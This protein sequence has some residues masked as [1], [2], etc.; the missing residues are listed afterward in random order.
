MNLLMPRVNRLSENLKLGCLFLLLSSEFVK[1]STT[2][3]KTDTGS[4]TLDF[5][6]SAINYV[7]Y[8]GEGEETTIYG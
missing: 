5:L 3:F 7:S 1:L 8:A 2:S 6:T 4:S